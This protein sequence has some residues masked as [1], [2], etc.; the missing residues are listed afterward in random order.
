MF[1][2]DALT[3]LAGVAALVVLFLVLSRVLRQERRRA[4][5]LAGVLV[6]GGYVPLGLITWP[7]ADVFAIH[8]AVFGIAAFILHVAVSETA[9]VDAD[10]VAV[11]RRLHWGPA[12]ILG[13]FVML[14]TILALLVMVA[15]NGMSGDLAA[16]FL[17]APAG[18]GQ[19]S[20]S[21]FPGTVARDFHKK[22][23]LY[24]RYLEQVERQ[25]ARGWQ[26]RY[27]WYKPSRP[28]AGSE[29]VFQ[30][31][32]LD[33][34]GG[35]VSGAT[36]AGRFMRSADFHRDREVMLEEVDL[37]LYRASVTLE[38]AGAWQVLVVITRGEDVH[39]IQARTTVGARATPGASPPEAP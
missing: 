25:Q 14:W 4:A 2:N 7:G 38:D 27:G 36:V 11:H 5:V 24:N 15:Q 31:Q 35:P 18:G 19:V 17:P 30:L 12:V 33:R 3:L 6:L 21:T 1:T 34:N 10:G 39:E 32:V 13:F 23:A 29:A 8:I 28:R 22:E 26:V 9:Q 37:G 16:R 20:Q